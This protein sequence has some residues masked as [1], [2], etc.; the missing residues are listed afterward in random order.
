M[1]AGVAVGIEV[2]AAGAADVGVLHAVAKVFV[3]VVAGRARNLT[4][5]FVDRDLELAVVFSA[6]GIFQVDREAGQA[7]L[8]E[9][10]FHR[11]VA[12]GF[13][14]QDLETVGQGFVDHVA[15]I[16]I[17][18]AARGDEDPFLVGFARRRGREV[19]RLG[20]FR[21]GAAV[22]V[23]GG[24]AK[25]LGALVL[26]GLGREGET[27]GSRE[28]WRAEEQRFFLGGV[29]EIDARR[30]IPGLPLDGAG[31][32]LGEFDLGL[33]VLAVGDREVGFVHDEITALGHLR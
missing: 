13:T 4:L 11:E 30:Q 6:E 2:S 31:H 18:L 29:L 16:G 1:Y 17:V 21:V 10:A 27:P 26:A 25:L 24:E 3:E 23:F 5:F 7:R 28:F 8:L 22:E 15:R 33:G 20:E 19:G 9:V 12:V 14:V 32:V